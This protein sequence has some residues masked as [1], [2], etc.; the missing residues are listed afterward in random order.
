MRKRTILGG[1]LA[2]ALGFNL[3]LAG[4]IGTAFTYQGQLSTGAGPATGLFDFEISLWTADT[5]P[6]QVGGT[7]G[8]PGTPVTNGLFTVVLDFGAG[9]FLGDARWLQINV[10]TNRAASFVTLS[11]RQVLNPAPNA[12]FSSQAGN[13]ATA[14]TAT[15]A[16]TATTAATANAVSANAVTAAGI[17]GGQVVKSLDGLSDVVSLNA[18]NYITIAT[19]GAANSLTLT[20]GPWLPFNATNTYVSSGRVG[21]GVVPVI[22]A[23][24]VV[25]GNTNLYGGSI[26]VG[27]NAIGGDAKLIHFGDM[28]PNG[29]GYVYL[30]ENGKDDQMELRAGSFYFNN[31]NVGILK[32][33][34]VTALDVNGTVSAIG[35]NVSGTAAANGFSGSGAGLTGLNAANLT[36]GT[37]SDA[38]LS[39]NV[40][41][42][43]ANQTFTA[44]KTFMQQVGIGGAPYSAMLDVQGDI[45][46]NYHDLLFRELSDMN[47]GVGWYGAS[48]LWNG[49]NIDGPVLYGC[50]GGALGTMCNTNLALRWL[51][52]GFVMI[53]PMNQNTGTL[54]TGVPALVFGSSS[55]EGISSK[56]TPGPGQFSLDFYTGYIN[57]MRIDS[58][59]NVGIGTTTPGSTLQVV[60]TM[61]VGTN[62]T[63]VSGAAYST[64]AGGVS[65]ILNSSYATIAGGV[66]N[67]NISGGN[68]GFIGGGLQ[69]S[70]G[71]RS[72]VGGGWKNYANA[73]GAVVGGEF[74]WAL[75]A[76]D[77]FIGGG[78]YNYV[79]GWQSAIAGGDYNLVNGYEAFVGGG[80]RNIASAERALV[81][82]GGYNNATGVCA[83]VCGGG[84]SSSV[85][86]DQGNIAGGAYSSILGGRGNRALADYTAVIGGEW[87]TASGVSALAA[88]H[89]ARA[90]HQGTFVWADSQE[91]D[92]DPYAQSG[93]Q[94]VIDSFNVRANGG[95]YLVTGTDAS[96]NI[97]GGL[98]C[99]VGTS[100]WATL[101]D[102]TSKENFENV[103]PRTVLEKLV[104][105]P[106]SE[107]SYKGTDESNRH[108]GPM[109]QDFN[110]TFGVGVEQGMGDKKFI[111]SGDVDGV[112]L[113]AIQGL[114]QKVDE[115]A[116]NKDAR[117]KTLEGKVAELQALVEKLVKQN[118][119]T[120]E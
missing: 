2:L 74:N 15:T 37:L 17:A 31:G 8:L 6:A 29:L 109:A 102:R 45:R 51:S 3:S 95:V 40:D 46:L 98:Y 11:P 21:I 72:F 33:N 97:T 96:G 65:N 115:Q 73:Q 1:C 113:A 38:R 62:H 91:A 32:S 92:F 59:G 78:A 120:R 85:L 70:V 9:A 61:Q 66:Y 10:R 19:N 42:L 56:R 67:T 94:G 108:I 106:I 79:G 107:W 49:L 119:A 50:G 20:A 100:G 76:G 87:N 114:N 4:P 58:T 43:N 99:K 34:A 69:N 104:S 60:G 71:S 116:Q 22:G 44:S 81:G 83:V 18:G 84:G 111:N 105:V 12:L 25:G 112:A 36:A 30:G 48:K 24:D 28:Q 82:G 53:D 64:I 55:G 14:A 89:R 63:F 13:A 80:S 7:I 86:P 88:G 57:R 117:I 75:G 110:E 23:L 39:P 35:L 54:S 27:A 47:H 77:N 26:H 118:G 103:D 90:T 16:V 93:P 5:G 101:S 52:S 68:Y 41:L